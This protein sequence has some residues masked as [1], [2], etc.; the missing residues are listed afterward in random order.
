MEL[1]YIWIAEYRCIKEQGFNFSPEY[2][3]GIEKLSEGEFI[4]IMRIDFA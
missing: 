3:C 2:E 4:W 1:I